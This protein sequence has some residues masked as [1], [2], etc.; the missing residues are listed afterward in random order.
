MAKPLIFFVPGAWHTPWA[1]ETVRKMLSDRGFETDTVALAS[2]G[3]NNANI[4]LLE[5]AAVVRSVLLELVEAGRDVFIVGHSYGSLVASNSI[6]GL[7]KHQRVAE[8]KEGGIVML[9]YLCA[10][11][12]PVEANLLIALDDEYP[13]WWDITDDGGFIA[14]TDAVKVLYADVQPALAAE[15]EAALKPMPFR[16]MMDKSQFAPFN[17][18]FEVGFVFSERD[19]ALGISLQRR[20]FKQFPPGSFSASL[21]SSHSPFLSMPVAL[22]GV[23][24]DAIK[25]AQAKE[26]HPISHDLRT[27]ISA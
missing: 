19:Q 25:H 11:V 23:I 27:A 6:Q 17:E 14:A 7:S 21:Q 15:A 13:D 24:Q 1:Y 12:V 4:G 2:V 9:L 16:V 10:L 5:D 20:M 3:A 8:G 18:G 26:L 22:T